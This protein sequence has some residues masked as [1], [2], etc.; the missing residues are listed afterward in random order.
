MGA[1]FVADKTTA[2]PGRLIGPVRK[3]DTVAPDAEPAWQDPK[4]RA[5]DPDDAA[6]RRLRDAVSRLAE[7]T[8]SR[9]AKGVSHDDADDVEGTVNT[10]DAIGFDPLPLLR[11]FHEHGAEVVVIG[12][13]AGIMHGSSELTGDLDLLWTGDAAQA[14][15]LAAAFA[16][17]AAQLTDDDGVP[18]AC[19]PAAFGLPKVQFRSAGASGDCCTPALP[20]GGIPVADF[21][22]RCRVVASG[23][24]EIRYLDRQ[25]LIDMRRAVGR[26]KD[27]RRAEELERLP[28]T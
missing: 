21:L 20:W 26:V 27:L 22:D 7:L 14:G 9:V 4:V 13:V 17:V 1:P 2:V 23:G 18:L 15:A 6:V 24:F 28:V 3:R 8:R 12:Q 19:E 16:S 5:Y 25:D 11:A 10:D